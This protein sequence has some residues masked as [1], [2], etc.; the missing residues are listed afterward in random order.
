[1]VTEQTNAKIVTLINEK[2][3]AYLHFVAF[4]MEYFRLVLAEPLN[5]NL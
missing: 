4:T 1:M 3:F 2:Y 5:F